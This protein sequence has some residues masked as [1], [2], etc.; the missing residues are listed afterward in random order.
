MYVSQGVVG[1][2]SVKAVDE[3]HESH[4]D[5]YKDKSKKDELQPAMS[6]IPLFYKEPKKKVK[7]SSPADDLNVG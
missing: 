6:D 2:P 7:L 4:S 5:I 1:L 3:Y